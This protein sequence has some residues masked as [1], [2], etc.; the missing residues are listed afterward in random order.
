MS[1][2]ESFYKILGV[3]EK[4][5][6]DEIKKAYRSLSLKH[7]P[8]RNNNKLESQQLFQKISEAY[9][10]LS[11]DQKREEYDSM[12]HNPFMRMNSQHGGGSFSQMDI[13]IDEIFQAFFGAANESEFSGFPGFPGFMG[14]RMG[15]RMNMPGGGGN[16]HIFTSNG[17]G[18]ND[19]R[20]FQ[21][22]T[23]IIKNIEINMEQVLNGATVP[24]DIDRWL[25]ENGNKIFEH[26]TLYITVPKG[27][28]DNEIIILREKGNVITDTLKGDVKIFIKIQNN[29]LF[30]R[31]GLDLILNKSISLKDA[32]CGFSFELKYLND[33][34]YTLNCNSGN[35]IQ[36][37][38]KKI[39]P[40]MGLTRESHTGNLIIQF[41]VDFPEKITLEQIEKLRE[42][43]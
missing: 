6:K 22:P 27:V 20:N 26:E 23:P 19:I 31:S 5:S 10:T 1:K 24:L 17:S 41:S 36:P 39:L 4:A 30:L 9:E 34:I 11:D 15:P 14:Q 43:L 37:G 18:I 42:I 25:I 3:S 13:P 28:D 38:Y 16:I 8:D 32:L 29:T 21:K 2:N 35:I 40:N 12:Q 7:H 33:K